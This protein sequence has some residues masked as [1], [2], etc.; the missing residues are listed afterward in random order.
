MGEQTAATYLYR[1]DHLGSVRELADAAGTMR[2]R[3]DYTLCG[4]YWATNSHSSSLTTAGQTLRLFTWEITT[5][6]VLGGLWNER[7]DRMP[8]EC[9]MA[10]CLVKREERRRLP[11]GEGDVG[12][13]AQW[14]AGG[15]GFCFLAVD[16]VFSGFRAVIPLP[17]ASSSNRRSRRTPRAVPVPVRSF[18]PRH[19][20]GPARIRR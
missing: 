20:S 9:G 2:V 12:G 1:R 18:S 19:R 10:V 13:S 5:A 6:K 3:Y 11:A 15:S 14:H 7:G 8:P 4:R 16:R 17:P